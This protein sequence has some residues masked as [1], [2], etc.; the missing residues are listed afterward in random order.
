MKLLLVRHGETGWSV[1]GQHTGLTDIPLTPNGLEQATSAGNA[2]RVVLGDEFA[3]ASAFSSPLSR[4]RVTAE[5]VMGADRPIGLCDELLE[6]DY[7]EY[8]GLTPSEIRARR[9]GWDI[10]ADGCPGGETVEAVGDRVDRFLAMIEDVPTVIAFAHGHVI[11]ILAARAV[12]LPARCGQIFT[13]DTAT[14]SLIADVRGKRVVKM[15]NVDPMLVAEEQ[16]V[17]RV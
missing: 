3:L 16:A 12:G 5:S 11:R 13:L 7:G 6:L 4:A 14:V 1:T 15:W 10:W 8:E 9:A 2:A 17:P